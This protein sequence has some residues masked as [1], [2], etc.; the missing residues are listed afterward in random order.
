V[1][2]AIPNRS[3]DVLPAQEVGHVVVL[4]EESIGTRGQLEIRL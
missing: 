3:K 2:I 1:T 4:V